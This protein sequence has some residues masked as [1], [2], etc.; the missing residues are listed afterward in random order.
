LKGDFLADIGHAADANRGRIHLLGNPVLGG[1]GVLGR[2][3]LG[4]RE[5]IVGGEKVGAVFAGERLGSVTP[6]EVSAM[7]SQS[8][9]KFFT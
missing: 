1:P 5:A 2:R 3:I 8:R 7:E 4:R 6:P 9:C